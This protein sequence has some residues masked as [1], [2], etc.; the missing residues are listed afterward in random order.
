MEEFL[1]EFLEE[2]KAIVEKVQQSLLLLEDDGK[3]KNLIT[4]IFRGIHT[5][6]GSARM[7]GFEEIEKVTHELENT[8]EEIR[9]G[10]I[11]LNHEIISMSLKVMDIVNDI[12]N[13][14]NDK[15]AYNLTLQQLENK[16]FVSNT[17]ENSL[18]EGIFQVLYSPSENIFERGIKPLAAIEE[19]RELGE[20]KVFTIYEGKSLE[21]QEAS[22]QFVSKFEIIIHLKSSV[23]EL[24]DV[25][26]FMQPDEFEIH[27]V[28]MKEVFLQE[29]EN[30]ILNLLPKGEQLSTEL[31]DERKQYFSEILDTI[32]S[33]TVVKSEVGEEES[34]GQDEFK[35]KLEPGI[36]NF[37]NVNLERLDEMMN[38]VS[39]LVSI[40]AELIYQAQKIGDSK[41]ISNM[42]RLDK[43]TTKFRDNAFSMRLVPLQVLSLKFQ[44]LV[45]ELGSK[46]GKEINLITEGLDTEIDKSIINEV[47]A[48]LMHIIQNAIDHGLE[49]PEERINGGKNPKGLLKIVA[50]YAGANVFI[51]VQDDGKGLNLDRIKEKAINNGLI[52][53]SEKLTDKE[54]INL[55]FEPGFTTND[56]VTAYSG[57][58]VGMDVVMNK[59]R[60]LR[61]SIDITTE[62][63]LGSAFTL[64]LPLSLSILEVLHVKV[65][66]IN[67][68]IPHSEI[69]QCF[70]ER[71]NN[72][73]IQRRGGN[74]K[75]KGNLIPLMNLMHIFDEYTHKKTEPSIIVI[76]KNDHFMSIEVDEIIGEEQLVIKPIDEALKGLIYLSGVSVLGNGELA[77]L[78][79]PL[80]LNEKQVEKNTYGN[81]KTSA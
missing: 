33:E 74:L 69:E 38:L 78:L 79:D 6:K 53:K 62:E 42:E 73:I 32:E 21:E 75:Y 17:V 51:Q 10:N 20:A 12:L 28:E 55:I 29:M 60:E 77:Y 70:S 30:R 64:R 76:N 81:T 36:I 56:T 4:E 41:L 68:L 49:K 23:E 50:F 35:K 34:Q 14:K 37:I 24:E 61:G 44:R 48:P 59:M 2:A 8:F 43:V 66:D 25:F 13:G 22:K 40:K 45:R 71:L 47:E 26:L 19:L 31:K 15:Q 18:S 27:K 7:F 46:L 52:S 9:D 5:L 39:D 65:G 54:I 16:D 3:N 72:D 63:G 11:N 67:Y 80:K 58:G 1:H 57:R